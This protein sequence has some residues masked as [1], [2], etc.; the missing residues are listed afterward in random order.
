V[1]LSRAGALGATETA[2][3]FD[4]VADAF[5]E[6]LE[7]RSLLGE[8]GLLGHLRHGSH[9]RASSVRALTTRARAQMKNEVVNPA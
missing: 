8:R 1:G 7:A 3:S 9:V 5:A 4:D 6:L 2:S